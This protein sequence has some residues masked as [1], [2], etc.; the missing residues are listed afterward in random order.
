MRVLPNGDAAVLVELSDL[1]EMLALYTALEADPPPGVVD[2]IP[3][4]RTVTLV[5]SPGGDP[6]AVTTA[7]RGAA[8]RA[9]GR[10]TGAASSGPEGSE[11]PDGSGG[12]G[13]VEIPVDYDGADLDEVA[14][15]TGLTAEEVVDA[16]TGTPWRVAFIG[17][18]PGFG[19]LVG[20]DPRLHVPRRRVPRV[21]VPAGSVALA[22][23]FSG[24]YPVGSPGGWQLIGR[25]DA[26]LWD[27]DRD[28][29]A[30]LR[31][32][33]RVRFRARSMRG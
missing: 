1:D 15:L 18:A 33:V 13:T 14:K 29:P 32:G 6:A 19:Y 25:T 17:F 27:L 3:A 2:L 12:P 22:D 24:L 7:V 30:L 11:G 23:E 26:P 5:L 16:H 28:P 8:E 21:R 10:P 9:R 4:A 20:G 31:P